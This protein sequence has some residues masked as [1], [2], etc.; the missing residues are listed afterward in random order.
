MSG[1]CRSVISYHHCMVENHHRPIVGVIP[2]TI[3]TSERNIAVI[4]RTV[5]DVIRNKYGD[6]SAAD[7]F[8]DWKQ[9]DARL[10]CFLGARHRSNIITY[11]TGPVELSPQTLQRRCY[12]HVNLAVFTEEETR[13]VSHDDRRE[14]ADERQEGADER[15]DDPPSTQY[16]QGRLILSS[17]FFLQFA[18]SSTRIISTRLSYLKKHRINSQATWE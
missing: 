17:R 1:W 5:I 13:W 8:N 3:F 14:G 16:T 18:E 9:T 10:G 6:Q 2:D 12:H 7:T 11:K 15:A 4:N